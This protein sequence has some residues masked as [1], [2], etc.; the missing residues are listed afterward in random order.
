MDKAI[1]KKFAIESRQDLMQRMEN[2]IKA[3]YIDEEFSKQQS[4]DVY[5]LANNKHSLSLSKEEYDKRE[6]LIKRINELGLDQVIEEAAYTWFNRIVAIRYMEIHDYLPLTKDNQSLGIR[7]LSSKDNTPDPEIMK[8]TNLVNPELDIEFKKEKYVELKDDNEKFKYILLLVCKKLGRVIPQVFDGVTDYIDILVPDNLLNESGFVNKI[9]TEVPVEN[10]DQVEIIG[11]LYQYYNQ[12]EKDR[13]ISAKKAYKKNEIAYATQLFTP[14]WIVKYMVENTLGKYWIEHDGNCNLIQNWKYYIQS[15]TKTINKTI[16]P[17]NIKCID[18]CSGSGHILVYMFEVLFQIYLSFGYSK[19]DI[20][21]LILKYNLYSVDIDD[22]AEQLSILSVI[23]KA[24]EVDKDIFNKNIIKNLNI[25]SIKETNKINENI[26]DIIDENNTTS[27]SIETIKY[28]YEVFKDAKEI[29]SLIN[30]EKRDY[31]EAINEIYKL[32]KE[33]VSMY[34][35]DKYTILINKYIP[36]LKQA[37]ILSQKYDIIVTNPPYMGEKYMPEKV[38]KYVRS[39]FFIGR[40]DMFSVFMLK[41]QKLCKR[42]GMIGM[43]TPYAWMFLD[44]YKELRKFMIDNMPIS[45]LIQLEF[46]AFEVAALPVCTFT[47]LNENIN[48]LGNYIKLSDFP[49]VDNQSIKVLEALNNNDVYYFYQCEMENFKLIEGFPISF[50]LSD[51]MRRVFATSKKINNYGI[52]KQGMVTGNNKRFLRLWF[53]PDFSKLKLDATSLEDAKLSE[54]KWFPYNKGGRYRK[55]YGNNEYVVN[56]ENDGEEVKKYTSHLPQG[57][58]VR[59]KSRDYYFKEAITWTFISID[60]GVRYSK[61]GA[62]FDVAG[63]SLFVET[64]YIKYILGFLC[65]KLMKIFNQILNPTMNVQISNV[66]QLPII[67]D[68][69]KLEEINTIVNE[70]IEYEKADWDSYELSWDFDTHPLIKYKNNETLIEKAWENWNKVTQNRFNRVKE[71]EQKLN[72]MFIDIYGLKDEID[73]TIEDKEITIRRANLE[74]DI[75]SFINYSVGCMFGRYSIDKGGLICAGEEYIKNNNTSF[76]V[77]KDNIIPITENIYFEDDIITKFKAFLQ[78]AYGKATLYNNLDF[79]A[80]TIGKKNGES[81]EATVRRYFLNDFFADHCNLYSVLG[82]GKRPIYWLFDSG[83]KNGF[84]C[85]IYIHRYNEGTIS[86][87]RLDY[88]HKMQNSYKKELNDINLKLTQDIS[89]QDKK[90]L[91]KKQSE[92]NSKLQETLEYDEKVAHI[93]DKKIKIDLDDGVV[94]NYAKFSVKNPKTEK[95]ETILAKIK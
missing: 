50:W 86:K 54:K 48:L 75:K 2:K 46:N 39:E 76:L 34:D 45:S 58:A 31:T 41:A 78:A 93:A 18:P 47:L 79:I 57:T 9:V 25:I 5:I 89:L 94:S 59:I 20:P 73:P 52:A 87:I 37:Q 11:W 88:L 6:L 21:K 24:R 92:I 85:L 12:N 69:K 28:V 22:R 82:S 40:T 74:K 66:A 7:V 51:N 77:D 36:I 63:S 44:S 81:S 38:K 53:E 32:K 62:I 4:G 56:Y 27:S 29:G 68:E 33:Q 1:L 43:I 70:N 49:G 14:D 16:D 3:F 23:L 19:T 80:E 61:Y 30:I 67:I 71:N 10:Y 8:F 15:S 90:D 95:V 13:V 84:K 35:L 26:F 65:T 55:W 91:L 72:E 17:I 60:I 64:K 42:S 83:K